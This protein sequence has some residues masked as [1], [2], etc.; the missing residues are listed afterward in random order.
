MRKI[1]NRPMDHITHLKNNFN[2]WT[3]LHKTN[4]LIHWYREK[5][6]ISPFWEFNGPLFVKF[7]APFT[8]LVETGPVVLEKIFKSC[9]SIFA[10]RL[11][12][13]LG[14]GPSYEQTGIPFTQDCFV[15]SLVETGLVILESEKILKFCQCICLISLFSPIGIRFSHWFELTWIPITQEHFVPSLVE[16][17]SVIL[18]KKMNMWKVYRQME[19]QIDDRQSEKLS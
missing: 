18:E 7:W 8:Q 4:S 6:S 10:F 15:P 16:I 12:F 2:Q 5:K 9:L 17:D 19:K 14:K 1:K 3:N 11:L 13:H